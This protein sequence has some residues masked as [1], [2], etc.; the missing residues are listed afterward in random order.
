MQYSASIRFD[1]CFYINSRSFIVKEP[2]VSYS[3]PT[4]IVDILRV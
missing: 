4:N 1:Y 2:V 3:Y